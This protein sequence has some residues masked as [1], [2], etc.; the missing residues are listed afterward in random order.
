MAEESCGRVATEEDSKRTSEMKTMEQ[1]ILEKI[2]TERN[3]ELTLINEKLSKNNDGSKAC[4]KCW[5]E[6]GIRDVLLSFL[7]DGPRPG[8]GDTVDKRRKRDA[9]AN[10]NSVVNNASTTDTEDNSIISSAALTSSSSSSFCQRRSVVCWRLNPSF[11][12]ALFG[13]ALAMA[14]QW[15][16]VNTFHFLSFILICGLFQESERRGDFIPGFGAE[17]G[18]E[19][20]IANRAGGAASRKR[21]TSSSSSSS[22][23]VSCCL[24]ILIIFVAIVLIF[25]V[26]VVGLPLL[27]CGGAGKGAAASLFGLSGV[28]SLIYATGFGILVALFLC[29]PWEASRIEEGHVCFCEKSPNGV[30]LGRYQVQD[31]TPTSYYQIHFSESQDALHTK[32][33]ALSGSSSGAGL[34]GVPKRPHGSETCDC[35][36]TPPSARKRRAEAANIGANSVSSSAASSSG[37]PKRRTGTTP[38]QLGGVNNAPENDDSRPI[39][40]KAPGD[41]FST[42]S[43]STTIPMFEDPTTASLEGHL[44]DDLSGDALLLMPNGRR[45]RDEEEEEEDEERRR[46]LER[47]VND[48][49]IVYTDDEDDLTPMNEIND[50]SSRISASTPQT[51]NGS[52]TPQQLSNGFLPPPPPPPL[53]PLPHNSH[54]AIPPPK[55][56]HIFPLPPEP[57]A[58]GQDYFVT[59]RMPNYSDVSYYLNE[60]EAAAFQRSLVGPSFNNSLPTPTRVVTSAPTAEPHYPEDES[61]VIPT[62]Q[63]AASA[64]LRQLPEEVIEDLNNHSR[65]RD[66]S[67]DGGRGGRAS[68]N[69]GGRG[70]GA[71]GGD[72]DEDDGTD[73]LPRRRSRIVT[74]DPEDE[75]GRECILPLRHVEE[76]EE[77]EQGEI[78]EEIPSTAPEDILHMIKL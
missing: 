10:P 44:A 26:I 35:H 19:D 12:E 38:T 20:A 53:P 74:R 78:P 18:D 8:S 9:G 72:D 68:Y 73:S 64:K 28:V 6:D 21:K 57:T 45:R 70:G 50:A 61:V 58:C 34:G 59:N 32:T 14:L 15:I 29:F 46:D 63:L 60:E 37:V 67:G 41:S 22:S 24:K 23:A 17:F 33:R 47:E 5:T 1:R 71:G 48:T 51:P 2:K 3:A 66:A 62:K 13:A 27:I 36:D 31:A 49:F 76:K 75:L 40:R 65:F 16:L 54:S 43:S 52:S 42:A 56:P 39:C 30:V 4:P 7:Q 25:L 77:E 11:D 69:G 55:P